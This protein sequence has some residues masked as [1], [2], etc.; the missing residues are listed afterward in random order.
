MYLGMLSILFGFAF[1][2]NSLLGLIFPIVFFW[3]MNWR[4]IPAEEK[5]IEEVFGDEYLAYKRRTRRWI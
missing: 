1:V 4:L 2:L 5:K 3:F